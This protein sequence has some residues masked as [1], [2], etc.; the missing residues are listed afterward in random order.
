MRLVN[1]ESGRIRTVL[2]FGIL[3]GTV[4]YLHQNLILAFTKLTD[5][6]A[7]K[8]E[9]LDPPLGLGR[10]AASLKVRISERGSGLNKL[11]LRAQQ[12]ERSYELANIDLSGETNLTQ[13]LEIFPRTLGLTE[14]DVELELVAFDRSFWS[15]STSHKF[16]LLV[17]YNPPLI[18]ILSTQHNT[19]VGGMSLVIYKITNKEPFSHGI[20]L[21]RYLF[22]GMKAEYMNPDLFGSQ[23]YFSLFPVPLDIDPSKEQAVVFAKDRVGNTSTAEFNQSI[24]P[25]NIRSPELNLTL[26]FLRTNLAE[27][28]PRYYE[29]KSPGSAPPVLSG[30]ES[31]DELIKMFRLIN[32]NFRKLLEEKLAQI[33]STSASQRMWNGPF[34]RMAAGQMSGY[35]EHRRYLYKGKDAGQS[36][37]LGAD[38]ASTANAT[39]PAGNN[40]IVVFADYLGIYGNTVIIDHGLGL[41]TL[42]GHLSSINVL[43]GQR[44]ESGEIIGRSGTTGLAGGDHLHFEVRLHGIAVS[45]HY[46]WDP[47]WIKAHIDKKLEISID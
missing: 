25:T 43:Q 3:L 14:G 28:L 44:I 45:P 23:I 40:G 36:Y 42:Y 2:L 15:N 47:L 17:E 38:L 32:E 8:I 9:L 19:A 10:D 13:T 41:H 24:R 1:S 12:N 20:R 26:S 7:P 33:F 21:G 4:V 11:I 35:G 37:H 39:I 5:R 46:L 34:Q 16:S 30:D 18:N 31:D 22:P 27:L 6:S 29:I